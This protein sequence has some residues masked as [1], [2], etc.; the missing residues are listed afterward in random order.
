MPV[1]VIGI[2]SVRSTSDPGLDPLGLPW[3]LIWGARLS[4]PTRFVH[5]FRPRRVPLTIRAGLR[6]KHS[7]KPSDRSETAHRS[8]YPH[9]RVWGYR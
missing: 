4:V 3:G 2:V 5:P 6:L 7:T 1:L 8:G 9:I